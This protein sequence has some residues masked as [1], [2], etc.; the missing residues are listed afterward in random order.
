MTQSDGRYFVGC[1]LLCIWNII[2]GLM[3]Q[4]TKAGSIIE[5]TELWKNLLILL[6]LPNNL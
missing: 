2:F 3:L 1:V 6:I 4:N 5:I